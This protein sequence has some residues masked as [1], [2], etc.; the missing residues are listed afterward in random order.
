MTNLRADVNGRQGSDRGV[1]LQRA[2]DANHAI[3]GRY[4]RARE[5]LTVVS[6]L[7]GFAGLVIESARSWIGVFGLLVA[8]AVFTVLVPRGRNAHV[9]A[10]V[11]QDQFDR[12]LYGLQ[13][14]AL[15]PKSVDDGDLVRAAKKSTRDRARFET[16][17]PDVTHLPEIV[18]VFLCQK[19]NLDWDKTLRRRYAD[20]L[21]LT[22][23]STLLL[24]LT[25][26]LIADLSIRTFATAFLVPAGPLVLLALT[27]ARTHREQAVYKDQLHAIA[28]AALDDALNRGDF[29]SPTGWG[30]ATEIQDGLFQLRCRTERILPWFYEHTRP[31][32][33]DTMSA[34]VD[35]VRRRF[36]SS[37]SSP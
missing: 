19:A 15:T 28:V 21:D 32:D 18:S 36:T 34:T 5:A 22:A 24:G 6:A 9:R 23:A 25:I 2:A 10:T 20:V 37:D 26:A 16:W 29:E 11:I 12:W 17:Y 27:S 1:Q 13:A 8:L 4:E 31:G 3:A 7:G 35:E 14:T 30:T 33:E